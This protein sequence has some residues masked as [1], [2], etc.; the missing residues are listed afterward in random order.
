MNYSENLQSTWNWLVS[1]KIIKFITIRYPK[2]INT[3]I[4]YY[5]LEEVNYI[6]NNKEN[7]LYIGNNYQVS[8]F[9]Q[10]FDIIKP[11]SSQINFDI[12][13]LFVNE[14]PCDFL[15]ECFIN[16]RNLSH[17]IEIL[18]SKLP[19][20]T[21]ISCQ[22]LKKLQDNGLINEFEISTY[23]L[24]HSK[25]DTAVYNNYI[26]SDP[27]K[28]RDCKNFIDFFHFFY[29]TKADPSNVTL[30]VEGIPI[31][32]LLYT[33]AYTCDHVKQYIEL[34]KKYQYKN[35]HERLKR[36]REFKEMVGAFENE[37]CS[38]I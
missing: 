30:L 23:Y 34:F 33:L 29:G 2:Y 26:L 9:I 14:I 15:L 6:D 10:A 13:Y 32:I 17:I 4:V 19:A 1:N 16:L 5:K 35:K 20:T 31:P 37:Y 24:Y 12:G 18:K 25:I 7:T 22:D 36:R 38:L 28:T 3:V 11:S 27:L 21:S 8:N